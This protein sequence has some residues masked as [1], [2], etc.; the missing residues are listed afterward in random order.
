MADELAYLIITPY[1]LAK[2]RTGAI[3]ARV[4]SLTELELVGIRMYKPSNA[5]VDKF[6]DS[7]KNAKLEGHLKNALTAYVDE[8]LREQAVLVQVGVKGRP[9]GQG[10]QRF[11]ARLPAQGQG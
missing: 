6:R 5:F 2:S 1:S 10:E 11:A 9:L 4:L 8:N 3:I 7:Y